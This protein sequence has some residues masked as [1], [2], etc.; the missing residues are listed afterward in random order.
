MPTPHD[1]AMLIFQQVAQP[2][3]RAF[4]GNT[5]PFYKVLHLVT[6]SQ[7]ERYRS[8]PHFLV[9]ARAGRHHFRLTIA[10]GQTLQPLEV[11]DFV[12]GELLESDHTDLN[13]FYRLMGWP[14]VSYAYHV[15]FAYGWVLCM[16]ADGKTPIY[17][18]PERGPLKRVRRPRAP[19]SEVTE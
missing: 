9:G 15:G 7:T 11:V 3:L 17:P 2:T 19:R 10:P 4:P 12:H 1:F 18:T 8:D 13:A 5:V 14:T 16:I 6:V